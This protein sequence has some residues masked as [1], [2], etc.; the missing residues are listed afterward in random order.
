MAGVYFW[1]GNGAVL[2]R[3]PIFVFGD[4]DLIA[5]IF[6]GVAIGRRVANFPARRR[7]LI[8]VIRVVARI[9]ATDRPV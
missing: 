3:F 5:D 8:V 9:A 1:G 2:G 7:R 4:A 6:S